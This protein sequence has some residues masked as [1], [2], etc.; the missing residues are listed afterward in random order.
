[1]EC[2]AVSRRRSHGASQ[3]GREQSAGERTAV[4][5]GGG[6]GA[7]VRMLGV[8]SHPPQVLSP[9]LAASP[10]PSS[11]RFGSGTHTS[12]H[13]PAVALGI[14]VLGGSPPNPTMALHALAR[15]VC[16]E[17]HCP[18]YKASYVGDFTFPSSHIKINSNF[19][20][21]LSSTCNRY[22]NSE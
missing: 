22:R 12:P 4:L 20:R 5:T 7:E 11:A 21:L 3:I 9:F 8:P 16:L 14:C 18:T 10:F 15:A 2:H 1:M 6:K 13:S 19:L 17:G